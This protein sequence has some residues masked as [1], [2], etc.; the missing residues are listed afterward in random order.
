MKEDLIVGRNPVAEAIRAG[1]EINKILVAEGS[2]E[3]SIKKILAD[4]RKL[5]IVIQTVDRNK[6]NQLSDGANHQGV[7]A[8]VSPYHYGDIETIVSELKE[9]GERI[10]VIICDEINDPHNLGSILRT[11]NASGAQAV[12]IPKRRSV[13]MTPTVVKTAAGAAEYVPVCRVTNLVRTIEFLKEAGVWI[14]AAD[15]DGAK[16]YYEADFK[17]NVGIVVGSEG[18]GVGRLI[19]EKCDHVVSI[20]MLGQVTSLNAS[21]AAAVLMYEVV[22]QSGAR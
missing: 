3:G 8:Y 14:T 21:V 2:S 22:R 4:A 13:A 19:K 6:L 17:G 16:P 5:G 12:I 7:L 11:A 9:K 20:P 15:M 10:F 1:H 18:V